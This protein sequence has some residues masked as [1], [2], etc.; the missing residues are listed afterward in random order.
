[1]NTQELREKLLNATDNC[2][3]VLCDV[4]PYASNGCVRG[5]LR[6]V[7][8]Y[9]RRTRNIPLTCE[10][11]VRNIHGYCIEHGIQVGA[12]DYCSMGAWGAEAIKNG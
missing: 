2:K 5:M 11:C 12:N 6:D 10:K 9:I 7:G 1:M 8:E 3:H 4:C